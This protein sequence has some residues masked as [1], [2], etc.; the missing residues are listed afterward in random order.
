MTGLL[1][2]SSPSTN[3]LMI[4][5]RYR[6]L[7]RITMMISHHVLAMAKVIRDISKWRARDFANES[8]VFI[9]N[10]SIAMV[11]VMRS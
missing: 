5:I 2:S 7:S 10:M 6:C 4:C 8:L 9:T 3:I 11:L 1:Q